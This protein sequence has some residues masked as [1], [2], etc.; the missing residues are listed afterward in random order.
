MQAYDRRTVGLGLLA[1][2]GCAAPAG[3]P[4]MI[5]MAGAVPPPPAQAGD[6]GAALETDADMSGRVTA[7]VPSDDLMTE[8]AEL[9][10]TS[11]AARVLII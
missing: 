9:A 4:V 8:L 2:T 3:P 10:R 5:N 6:D 11:G 1:L 7:P